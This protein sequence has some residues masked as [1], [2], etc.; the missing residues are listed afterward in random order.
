M[1]AQD[2]LQS[3]GLVLGLGS[4]QLLLLLLKLL[5]CFLTGVLQTLQLPSPVHSDLA[6]LQEGFLHRKHTLLTQA[7]QYLQ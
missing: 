7:N 5:L 4:G 2:Y 3:Q 1:C 6:V